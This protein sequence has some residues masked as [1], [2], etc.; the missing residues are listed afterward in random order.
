MAPNQA[1]EKSNEKL[2]YSNLQDRRVGKQPK[3]KL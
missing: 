2:V 1:S 3:F